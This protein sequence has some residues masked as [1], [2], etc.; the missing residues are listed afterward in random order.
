MSEH[1]DDRFLRAILARAMNAK[2][3]PIKVTNVTVLGRTLNIPHT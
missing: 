2:G 1:G 3:A